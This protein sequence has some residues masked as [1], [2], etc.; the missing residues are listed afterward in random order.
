MPNDRIM[1]GY[2]VDVTTSSDPDGAADLTESGYCFYHLEAAVAFARQESPVAWDV[3]IYE[4]YGELPRLDIDDTYQPDLG[5][6][7]T[8]R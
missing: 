3:R 4:Y 2:Y 7:I 1:Q 5:D 8:W 6:E